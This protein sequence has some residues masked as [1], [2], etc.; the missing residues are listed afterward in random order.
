MLP[1]RMDGKKAA[2]DF[3]PIESSPVVCHGCFRQA[4]GQV[5][6]RDHDAV[7]H[8]VRRLDYGSR[9]QI[10][11]RAAAG[12]AA[13]A[14]E[15]SL[16]PM[17]TSYCD[18]PGLRCSNFVN[19]ASSG[20]RRP[21]AGCEGSNGGI[22]LDEGPHPVGPLLVLEAVLGRVDECP[23]RHARVAQ[24]AAVFDEFLRRTAD[25]PRPLIA[26]VFPWPA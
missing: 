6:R 8:V 24:M 2:E 25:R 7:R 16:L 1:D 9:V 11:A 15:R 17:V 21:R 3:L 14:G 23:R 26:A 10:E 13:L 22:A 4:A 19:S 18:C 20:R 12:R 5:L